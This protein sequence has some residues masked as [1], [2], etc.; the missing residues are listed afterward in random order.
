MMLRCVKRM[1]DDEQAFYMQSD[2]WCLDSIHEQL[3]KVIR[4]L[5][6]IDVEIAEDIFQV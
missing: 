5:S 2:Q 4:M 3:S 6:E 1:I